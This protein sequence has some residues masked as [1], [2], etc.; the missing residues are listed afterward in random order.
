[1]AGSKA[2]ANT[3]ALAA[4]SGIIA[5]GQS[6]DQASP[7]GT[8]PAGRSALNGAGS[9]S[10]SGAAPQSNSSSKQKIVAARRK[11][12]EG[13]IDEAERLATEC[14]KMG[15]KTRMFGESPEKLLEEIKVCKTQDAAWKKDSTSNVSKRARSNYL[16]RRAQAVYEEGDFA[17]SDRLLRDAEKINLQRA[18]SDLNPE[19]LRQQ[20]VRKIGNPKPGKTAQPERALLADAK[21]G[22]QPRT[23]REVA[24]APSQKSKVPAG[25]D[26][27]K[28]ARP[29]PVEPDEEPEERSEPVLTAEGRSTPEGKAQTDEAAAEEQPDVSLA[30]DTNPEAASRKNEAAKP[31]A[32]P[33]PFELPADDDDS[34]R[35]LL[36]PGKTLTGAQP[37]SQPGKLLGSAA[38]RAQAQT[39]LNQ[40]Q[41]LFHEGKI[42]EARAKIQQA[43]KLDVAYDLLGVTPEHL[44]AQIDRAESDALLAKS[45]PAKKSPATNSVSEKKSAAPAPADDADDR[46]D[47]DLLPPPKAKALATTKFTDARKQEEQQALARKL[48]EKQA[49]ARKQAEAKQEA[50]ALMQEAQDDLDA[51]RIAQAKDKA[52]R[53]NDMEVV[54]DLLD[55]TPDKLLDEATRAEKKAFANQKKLASE[56]AQAEERAKAEEIALARKQARDDEQ[57]LVEKKALAE[58]KAV[59]ERKL[60]AAEDERH[61]AAQAIRQADLASPDDDIEAAPQQ[62][63]QNEVADAAAEKGPEKEPESEIE[64]PDVVNPARVSALELYQRGKQAIRSGDSQLAVQCYLQAHQSGERLDPRRDQEIRDYLAQH[65]VKSK[66]IQLLSARQ[67]HESD[68]GQPAGEDVPERAIDKVDQQRLV[69]VDKLRAET[70]NTVFRAEGLA[71]TEPQK[72]LEMIDKAQANVE[73]SGLDGRITGQLLKQL[74]KSRSDIEYSRKIN[75]SKI[76]MAK[77]KTEVQET[78][79]LE[80]QTKIRIEQDYADKVEKYNQLLKEKRFDEAIVVGKQARLLMPDN[81]MS[82]LMVLKAKF[83]KQDDFN[84]NL[85][86]KKGDVFTEQLNKAE[87]AITGYVED[88]EYPELKKWQAL[89]DRRRKFKRADNHT[90]T[91]EELKIERSLSRDV[92][93][94]FD[95]APLSDVIKQ[96][97]NLAEVNMVL[98][99]SGLE[100]EGVTSSSTVSINVEGIRLKSALNLL[101]EPLRLGYTIKDDV[102]NITSRMQQQGDLVTLTY[103]V[104]DLVVPIRDFSPSMG[105]A[106]MISSGYNAGQPVRPPVSAMGQMSVGSRGSQQRR[107]GQSFAQFD[108]RENP[109]RGGAPRGSS[110]PLSNHDVGLLGGGTQADFNTLMNLISTTVQPDTWEDLSGPGSMQPYRTTLSLVIRQ[111]QAVHEE[112]AD[113]LGQ[114]RRLQDLQVTI[115]CRFITVQ[116]NFFERIGIDFNFNL[117]SNV[118]NQVP[119]TFGQPIQPFGNGIDFSTAGSLGGQQQGQGGQQGGGQQGGQQSGGQQSTTGTTAVNVGTTGT[120]GAAAPFTAGPTID[121]HN[122]STWP[123][124]G[125]VVGLLPGNTFANNL[126]IPFQQGSFGIGVPT[127]GNFN[128]AAGLQVGFA[129]LSDIETFFLINAAQGDS[130]NNLLF[131]PKVTLFNGQTANVRDN[132]MRPFVTSLTPTVGFGA[133]GFTPQITVLPEGVTMTV[134]AVISADRRY[135]RLTVIPSFTAITDVQEFSFVSGAGS[136]TIQGATGNSGGAAGGGGGFG[137]GNGA[138]GGQAGF[139]GIGGGGSGGA[140]G[141][142]GQQGGQAGTA[143]SGAGGQGGSSTTL[144]VQR[145]IFEIVTV[146]TT[147]S[148]PDGGTV[149]LGGIKRVREGR[150]MA[151]VPILNKIPYVSRLFKNTGVGRETQSLML[152]VTPRIIIQEEEEELLGVDLPSR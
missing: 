14:K 147:V 9:A 41:L 112:I 62:V 126:D 100:E 122:Q 16:V 3:G 125:D 145:P 7:S 108:D 13:K 140:G 43:E 73:N 82:E 6:A 32:A 17:N 71:A 132:V 120:G 121:T 75:A 26:R 133:V 90:P 38:D 150:N 130:R 101:L 68:V 35:S 144:T 74:A 84:K 149:L 44:T 28:I 95:D 52:A 111:T 40:A 91:P 136:S 5:R 21:R 110:D 97:A 152:M 109:R 27:S 103:S 67:V 94:H 86:D 80:E 48:A 137:G 42:E 123:R 66:K 93:L 54:W 53:A 81:P 118:G 151:G 143:Q 20:L 19:P 51:G 2:P 135:V 8:K 105:S 78:I 142:G 61:L 148:V 65:R 30:A 57:A 87:L 129:I 4:E 104:A 34:E 139:G 124:Y 77:R 85:R 50:L 146:Q 127:F 115:E 12:N 10:G 141:Q 59:A 107:S 49:L 116:D 102:L 89:T 69:A 72:A 29:A 114:L 131:A 47:D 70:R 37:K 92:S 22:P 98:D 63:A 46:L 60:Q 18:P 113:L 39:L 15:M 128:P 45:A 88:I 76:E 64:I 33:D 96:L 36:P 23:D 1:M 24:E 83:A 134:Q 55:M 31:K 106:G 25:N 56:K 58:K 138:G 11:F 79:K 117:A 99:P 119:N